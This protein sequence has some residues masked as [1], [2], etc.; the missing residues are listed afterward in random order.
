VAGNRVDAGWPVSRPFAFLKH[1]T[2]AWVE[3]RVSLTRL[4]PAGREKLLFAMTVYCVICTELYSQL[5]EEDAA[6]AGAHVMDTTEIAVIATAVSRQR[7]VM[8]EVSSSG[9]VTGVRLL[10]AEVRQW[11][12][13]MIEDRVKAVASVAHDRY[14]SGLGATDGRYPSPESVAAAELELYF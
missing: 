5:A 1:P 4:A 9:Y 12:S 14:L 7:T 6:V 3:S 10:S 2:D 13:Q 8:V 11:D